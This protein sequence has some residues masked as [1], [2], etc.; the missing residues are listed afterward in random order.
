[1]FYSK[2]MASNMVLQSSSAMPENMKST[3]L[4]QEVIFRMIN[5]SEEVVDNFAHKII[6]SGYG[7]NQ[8]RN[9]MVG[10][11]QGI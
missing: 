1:M 4:N 9:I 6:N 11:A 10:G 5:S 2:P 3:T 8:T 7:L